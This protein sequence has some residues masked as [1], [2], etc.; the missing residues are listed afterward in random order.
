MNIG[1]LCRLKTATSGHNDFPYIDSNCA[2]PDVE[3]SKMYH[4]QICSSCKQDF[5]LKIE[6]NGVTKCTPVPIVVENCKNYADNTG[7]CV[8]C[9]KPYGLIDILP[10]FE[11]TST[12]VKHCMLMGTGTFN[13][14]T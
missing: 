3:L 2:V 12:M 5:Y 7:G 4:V 11:S 1:G 14:V 6:S 10:D 8:S 13:T 9:K